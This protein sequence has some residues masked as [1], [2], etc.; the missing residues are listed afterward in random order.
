MSDSLTIKIH[1]NERGYYVTAET[2]FDHRDW[3]QRT[4]YGPMSASECHSLVCDLP[5]R[6]LHVQQELFGER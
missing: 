6:F 2:R 5:I 4:P 3:I 1:R